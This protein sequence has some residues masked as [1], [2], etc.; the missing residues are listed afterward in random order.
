MCSGKVGLLSWSPVRFLHE[1]SK[2]MVRSRATYIII[3]PATNHMMPLV[4]SI[5]P[6]KVSSIPKH[7]E[8]FGR[9]TLLDSD[10]RQPMHVRMKRI[11]D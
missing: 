2:D 4:I 5:Q 1:S 9:R 11:P 8:C 6:F 3:S 10:V 7:S